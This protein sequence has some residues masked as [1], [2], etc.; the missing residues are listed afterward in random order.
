MT[1]HAESG[2]VIV[3][4]S[5]GYAIHL[6]SSREVAAARTACGRLHGDVFPALTADYRDVTCDE[7][8]MSDEFRR[9]RALVERV[10]GEL[11]SRR[12]LARLRP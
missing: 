2:A 10:A 6:V 4:G 9:V 3:E 1:V 5:S 11:R 12:R 7:C 8:R